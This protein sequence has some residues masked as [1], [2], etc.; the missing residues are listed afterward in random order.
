MSTERRR[1]PRPPADSPPCSGRSQGGTT[2]PSRRSKRMSGTVLR[3]RSAALARHEAKLLRGDPFPLAVL[4][5]MP[6]VIIVF[7]RPAL[8]LALFAE[9]H[10]DANGSEQAVP[11]M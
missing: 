7:F 10:V 8:S 1:R 2:I 5:V 11:G 9:G 3:P 6:L 4:I